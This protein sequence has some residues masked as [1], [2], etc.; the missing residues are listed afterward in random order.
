MFRTTASITALSV[1]LIISGSAVAGQATP[2]ANAEA[3]Q[4]LQVA[5]VNEREKP[6]ERGDP[7][8]IRGAD[9]TDSESGPIG[10][11]AHPASDVP[12]EEARATEMGDP[13]Y[14]TNNRTDNAGEP[15]G[16]GLIDQTEHPAPDVPGQE[17]ADVRGS[18]GPGNNPTDDAGEPNQGGF[19]DETEHPAPQV[20]GKDEDRRNP[21][22]GQLPD[23]TM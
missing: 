15:D 18:E 19:I 17:S 20:P 4:S 2:A 3:T 8:V 14:T 6:I 21:V 16:G 23:E 13:G 5:D 1:G 7:G 11:K 10:K 12:G 22:T 9:P